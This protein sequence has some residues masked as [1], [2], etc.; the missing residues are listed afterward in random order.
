MKDITKKE[1]IKYFEDDKSGKYPLGFD[2]ALLL[3]GEYL[4]NKIITEWLESFVED[5]TKDL[6]I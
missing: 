2:E 6:F 4:D 3:I 5:I 1:L